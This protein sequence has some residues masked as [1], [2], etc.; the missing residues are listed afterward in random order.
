MR[1]CSA[2]ARSKFAGL[3]A[4]PERGTARGAPS[5]GIGW[6]KRAFLF[7]PIYVRMRNPGQAREPVSSGAVL[8]SYFRAHAKP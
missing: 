2:P 7:E 3:A 8:G 4:L 5:R 6:L 1:V